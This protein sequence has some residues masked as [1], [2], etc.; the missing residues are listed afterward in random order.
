MTI[1]SQRGDSFYLRCWDDY[2]DYSLKLTS[3]KFSG[4]RNIGF[5]TASKESLE[6]IVD[7]LKEDDEIYKL[8][9][10]QNEDSS[11]F[12]FLS[13]SKHILEVYYDTVWYSPP[14]DEL[15]PALKNQ[16]Q[17]FPSRGINVRRLDHLS[18][19]SADVGK[20]RKF[21]EEN[22]GLRVTEQIKTANGEEAC[23]MRCNTNKGYDISI[24]KDHYGL[25]GRLHHCAFVVDSREEVLRA[26]DICL[27][28]KVFIETGPHKHAIQQTFFLYIYEPGGNRLEICNPGARLVLAP[29][30][31]PIVWNEIERAKGQAWGLKTI[32]AFHLHG[33]P[34]YLDHREASIE[35]Q[36]FIESHGSEKYKLAHL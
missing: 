4:V 22:L 35:I 17:S 30:W 10:Y 12:H 32:E 18:V 34:E 24:I 23:W 3:S 14:N 9:Y 27:E 5:R 2:E 16:A 33:T 13:P 19:L 28:K 29:D 6:R 26:A 15:K 1:S 36:R 25:D 31:K 20:S 8:G 21:Y 7:N 11:G